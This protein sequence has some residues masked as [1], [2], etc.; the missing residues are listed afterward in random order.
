MK[1]RQSGMPDEATW[2]GFFEPEQVLQ[3]LGLTEACGDVV[4]FGCGYGTFTIPAARIC[5]GIVHTL[6]IEPEM[7]AATIAKARAAGLTNLDVRRRDF[8]TEGTGLA[9]RLADH[10][11]L[12]NILHAEQPEVLLREAQRVLRP[13]GILLIHA[14]GAANTGVYD[15]LVRESSTWCG[16]FDMQRMNERLHKWTKRKAKLNGA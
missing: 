3:H 15:N 9:D 1:T 4:E 6:D 14:N 13:G 16:W 7:V 2:E 10:V 8:V 5:R 11:M 12:F